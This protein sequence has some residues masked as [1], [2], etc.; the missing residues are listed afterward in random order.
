MFAAT[1][2]ACKAPVVPTGFIERFAACVAATPDAVAV[3]DALTGAC[4]TYDQLLALTERFRG[5]FEDRRVGR[6][7]AVLLLLPTSAELFAA[8]FALASLGAMAVP[9]NPHLTDFELGPILVDAQPIGMVTSTISPAV[10]VVIPACA[11]LRFVLTGTE[12][13]LA[14][15]RPGPRSPAAPEVSVFAALRPRRSRLVPPSNDAVVS[16]HFTYRGLGYPLG[17]LHT[18]EHYSWGVDCLSRSHEGTQRSTH[19]A[20]LPLNAIYGLVA[21][22]LVPLC[23][24]SRI[25]ILPSE[26]H[27]RIAELLVT[28]NVRVAC[29]VPL[30]LRSLLGQAQ[31]RSL[32]GRVHPDLEIVSGGSLLHGDIIDRAEDLI[33]VTPF[34]GY[35]LTEALPVT[36]NHGGAYRRDS[37]GVA[38]C[39]QTRLE[40]VDVN[41]QVLPPGG[42]G[43]LLVSGP[44][45]M[46]GYLRRP[47]ET[48]LHLRNGR[49]RTGDIGHL[50]REGFFFF[51]GRRSAFTKA[52]S[53]M[54][55]LTEVERVLQ[56]HPA[57]E[58]ARVNARW[59]K[60]I[61]ERL[62]A[63]VAVRRGPT[64]SPG[65][66]IAFCRRYLS[67]HKVP[68]TINL[69]N[70]NRPSSIATQ[71]TNT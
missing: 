6:G 50:D 67:G 35:G 1:A 44:T 20:S 2:P 4:L 58:R 7:D 39:A 60:R 43:E 54:V 65:D 30:L 28:R 3:E 64:P 5:A 40:I 29:F 33:G 10:A 31:D 34:Q 23:N 38:I 59:D 26:Q 24:G 68:R 22:M 63:A 14:S 69:V 42:V 15:L 19:L 56:M 41:D 48:A 52:A 66:L 45:V 11:S 13:D 61:G 32:R 57:V 53:Q 47:R 17:A 27:P 37:V 9:V 16:C 25:L 71:G 62:W 12:V 51:R 8:F 46:S 55:D 36:C 21:G 70:S 18:Y 49:L